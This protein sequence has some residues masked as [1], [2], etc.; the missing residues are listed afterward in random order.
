MMEIIGVVFFAMLMTSNCIRYRSS[1]WNIDYFIS[2][3]YH[4]IYFV[5]SGG[6]SDEYLLC[7]RWIYI[8]MFSYYSAIYS[9]KGLLL[10]S[11]LPLHRL[12]VTSQMVFMKQD[13]EMLAG[14][15]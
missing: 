5:I 6:G 3:H 11:L 9:K 4:F 8:F 2:I 10:F 12:N 7:A 13:A 15:K 1:D 14:R